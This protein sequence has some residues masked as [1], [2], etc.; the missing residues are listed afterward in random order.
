MASPSEPIQCLSRVVGFWDTLVELTAPW[1]DWSAAEGSEWG[2]QG[3][4]PG[5]ETLGAF[6][7][8]LPTLREWGGNHRAA[9]CPALALSSLRVTASSLCREPPDQMDGRHG[10]DPIDLK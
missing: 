3:R 9:R 10:V 7:G 2:R 1:V 4:Q 5:G 8:R 6:T